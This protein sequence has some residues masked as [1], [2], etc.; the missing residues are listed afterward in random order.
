MKD[1]YHR[2][3]VLDERDISC[4]RRRVNKFLQNTNRRGIPLSS[5]LT[6]VACIIIIPVSFVNMVMIFLGENG[7]LPFIV[8]VSLLLC[9]IILLKISGIIL[10]SWFKER[11]E[12]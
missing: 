11:R 2:Y 6:F 9:A 7:F 8:S 10:N 4:R 3:P 5:L 1:R 12:E